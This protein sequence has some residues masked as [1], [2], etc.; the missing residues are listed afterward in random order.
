MAARR[1]PCE[2]GFGIPARFV[3][4]MHTGRGKPRNPARQAGPTEIASPT[5]RSL[6]PYRVPCRHKQ[7]TLRL[8]RIA[9]MEFTGVTANSHR[10]P[11]GRLPCDCL[12]SLHRSFGWPTLSLH[13]ACPRLPRNRP[14]LLTWRSLQSSMGPNS[15]TSLFFLPVFAMTQL[16]IL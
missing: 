8:V 3:G 15:A 7:G 12:R 16:T 6:S 14:S 2:T 11:V 1:T 5:K 9:F 10:I 4:C 13:P